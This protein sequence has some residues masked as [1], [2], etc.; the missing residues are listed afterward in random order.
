MLNYTF[1]I[2]H[3]NSPDLLKRCVDSI[4]QRDDVQIIVVDDN[5]NDEL[6]PSFHKERV[7]VKYLNSKEA[8]WAGHARNVGLSLAEGKWLLF[9]DADDFYSDELLACL[10]KYKDSN[11]DV[12]YFNYFR[13]KPG[14][15]IEVDSLI[16]KYCVNQDDLDFIKYRINA[17]WNKMVRRSFVE[18][19]KI[20]F[21]ETVNGNDMFFTYQI[22]FLSKSIV[23]DKSAIYYYDTTT[24]GMTNNRRNSED[25]YLCRLNHWYQTNAFFSYIG[26]KKW[27]SCIFSRLMAVLVNKGLFQFFLCIKVYLKHYTSIVNNKM[28]FVNRLDINH[29][30]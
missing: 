7:V 16:E 6:K 3:K 23:M 10:D 26:H 5:S 8:K 14:N 30:Q 24:N 22:G 25:Y 13:I 2:P 27:Q 12:V 17:P 15:R 11:Y 19:N 9:A 18:N 29:I 1:I 4:P 20:L 21:E 28:K